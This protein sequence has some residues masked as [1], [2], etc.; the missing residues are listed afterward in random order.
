[1]RSVVKD[2]P[3]ISIVMP[4]YNGQQFLTDAVESILAQSFPEF[5]FIIIDDGSTDSTFNLLQR[6]TG[7]T[8]IRL[9]KNP[10]NIGLSNS[11]NIGI[12]LSNGKYIARMDADDISLSDRLQ[13][14]VEYME[15]HPEVGV[16]G[17]N[18]AYIDDDGNFKGGGRPKDKQLESPKVIEWL[19]LWRCCIYHPT[20]MIRRA[21]LEYTGITYDPS[22][23][24][25]E[26]H[27]LW[28]K[29]SKHT[30]IAKL[31]QVLVY[32][33]V[34]IH[35]ISR[36]RAE[37]QR[38]MRAL[39]TRREL[40]TLLGE[41]PSKQAI[42]V[43]SS[44]LH[45]NGLCPPA[46]ENYVSA[47]NILVGAYHRFCGRPLSKA[48]NAQ[49]KAD[50]ANRLAITAAQASNFSSRATSSVL[51]RLWRLSPTSFFSFNIGRR[52]ARIPVR[53]LRGN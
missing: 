32:Y 14:Q 49:I 16:L 11:L 15:G 22:F 19:L 28:T 29:L 20:V 50:V 3:I 9:I 7:D 51:W 47:A 27:D 37:E 33:R 36:I 1:M 40:T 53:L 13:K 52:L 21:I 6:F 2:S 26:D 48:D 17:T 25:S 35:S 24:P 41:Q 39:I 18:I 4:V 46:A 34:S 44:S 5:E 12:L 42:E 10:T 43:L 30:L 23:E 45:E 38:K 31:P 8:R